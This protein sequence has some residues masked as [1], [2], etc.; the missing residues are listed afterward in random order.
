MVMFT[1]ISVIGAKKA[2]Q[3]PKLIIICALGT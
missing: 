1:L 2:T 3:V